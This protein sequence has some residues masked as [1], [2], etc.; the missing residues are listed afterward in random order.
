M[1]AKV[2][3][4]FFTVILYQEWSTLTISQ[5]LDLSFRIKFQQLSTKSFNVTSKSLRSLGLWPFITRSWLA[6]LH[7]QMASDQLQSQSKS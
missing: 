3:N 6:P 5:K 1:H 4:Y 7:L 2:E